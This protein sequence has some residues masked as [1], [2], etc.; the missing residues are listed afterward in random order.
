MTIAA[1]QRGGEPG[2]AAGRKSSADPLVSKQGAGAHGAFSFRA[3]RSGIFLHAAKTRRARSGGAHEGT[4]RVAI[5]LIRRRWKCSAR[6][7]AAVRFI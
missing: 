5:S 1:T 3:E 7:W 2:R 6:K 4:S